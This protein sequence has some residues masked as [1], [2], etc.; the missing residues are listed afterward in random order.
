MVDFDLDRKFDVVL[1]LFSS[2]GYARS[3]ERLHRTITNFANHASIGGVV[4]VEPWIYPEDF[5]P[6][7]EHAVFVDQP[8]LKIARMDVIEVEGHLSDVNFHYLVAEGG[9]VRYFEEVHETRMFTQDEYVEA[10][11]QAG[12]EVTHDPEGLI[13]RG[14]YIGQ[15]PGQG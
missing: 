10:F 2:I 12:L 14:L 3:V 7:K 11:Q 5:T 1:N 13:G 4:I 6:G 15:V 9:K 8:E